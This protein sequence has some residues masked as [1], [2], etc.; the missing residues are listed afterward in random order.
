MT[1]KKLHHGPHRAVTMS[2]PD[3]MYENIW[4][5]CRDRAMP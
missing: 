2:V 5:P 3:A 1:V 4:D